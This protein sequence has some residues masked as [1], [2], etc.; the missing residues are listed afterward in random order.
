MMT[1]NNRICITKIREIGAININ[2]A[3]CSALSVRV[4]VQ[5]INV[6][7]LMIHDRIIDLCV[8]AEEPCHR[9]RIKLVLEKWEV[10]LN[11]GTLG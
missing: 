2:G 1:M 3:A 4:V 8:L 11:W 6:V 10:Y 7:G 9:L 5:I